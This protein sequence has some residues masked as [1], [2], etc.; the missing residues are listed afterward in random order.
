MK[1]V[2]IDY[3]ENKIAVLE[4]LTDYYNK[5]Y[6]DS[7]SL[8]KHV[9]NGKFIQP[10]SFAIEEENCIIG[11]I[12]GYIDWLTYSLRIEDLFVDEKARGT[13]AGRLL[14]TE[15]ENAAK[16]KGCAITFVD[17]T[18]TSSP[19][20]YERLG[21]SSIGELKN[22]PVESDIYYFLKLQYQVEPV[23]C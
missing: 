19:K 13:G 23:S 20:F 15:I 2:K 17:T 7:G 21:Y 3:K 12:V 22:Y 6:S 18:R 14:V 9:A 8:E 16:D 10:L 1:L 5:Q 11:R 4:G